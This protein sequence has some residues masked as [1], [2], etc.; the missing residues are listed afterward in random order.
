M[1]VEIRD[2]LKLGRLIRRARKARGL[3]QIGLAREAGMGERFI[4]D[5]E[6]GKP[7]CEAGRVLKVLGLLELS[8]SVVP[9]A[10]VSGA[11]LERDVA[12]LR[13]RR[14]KPREAPAQPVPNPSP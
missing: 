8:L 13:E 5:L 4:V 14:Q 9:P 1:A 7:T 3:T 12:L 6:H 10:G 2:M 11:D